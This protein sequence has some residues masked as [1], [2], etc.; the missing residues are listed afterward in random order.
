MRCH[1]K[2]FVVRSSYTSAPQVFVFAQIGVHFPYMHSN[3]LVSQMRAPLKAC[4]EPT[5]ELWQLY[6]VL[7]VFEK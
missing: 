1:F 7:Y 6:K 4:R 5:G 2:S 3:R